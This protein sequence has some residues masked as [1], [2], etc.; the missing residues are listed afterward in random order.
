MKT[1]LTGMALIGLLLGS[2]S[3]RLALADSTAAAP[4]EKS[5]K[6]MV[7]SLNQNDRTVR[8][9]G[10]LRTRLMNI[11]ND[12]QVSLEGQP[13][14]PADLR[15]GQKVDIRYENARGVLVAHRIAQMN[16]TFEGYIRS[17]DPGSHKITVRHRMLDKDFRIADDCRV[18]LGD[19]K[20]GALG[21]LK[22]G[23]RVV[24]VYETPETGALMRQVTLDGKTFN[25]TLTA[26]DVNERTLKAR[27]LL[28]SKK[29]SLARDCRIVIDGRT[30]SALR[31][32]RIGDP[33]VLNYED[34][35]GVLVASR[36]GRGT[37]SAS[38]NPSV[39]KSSEYSSSRQMNSHQ[40]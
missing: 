40:P 5:L 26:I 33:V 30:D 19:E 25:G 36:V 15:P 20:S 10:L 22:V 13:A 4:H 12:C 23:H 28:G 31:D 2:G 6:G 32:L 8:V 3:T 34:V 18:M 27:T 7:V 24:L 9:K 39:A 37:S 16:Q 17:I 38:E 11:A 1:K 14:T 35:N 21:D 29:F